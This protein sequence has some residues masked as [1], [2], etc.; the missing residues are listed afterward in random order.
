MNVL[1][2]S[3]SH[4]FHYFNFHNLMFV[5]GTLNVLLYSKSHLS[6]EMSGFISEDTNAQYAQRS[7]SR[8]H[9]SPSSR[10]GFE[11]LELWSPID[12]ELPEQTINHQA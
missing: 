3:K 10:H 4:E 7:C 1:L 9:D 2:Y 6:E 5:R 11:Q 12:P 8:Q